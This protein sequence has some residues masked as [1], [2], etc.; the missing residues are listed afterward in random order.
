MSCSI[1]QSILEE[2]SKSYNVLYAKVPQKWSIST[3][4]YQEIIK[5]QNLQALHEWIQNNNWIPIPPPVLTNRSVLDVLVDSDMSNLSILRKMFACSILVPEQGQ[6][7]GVFLKCIQIALDEIL[8]NQKTVVYWIL[9]ACMST[10][11]RSAYFNMF[12]PF[13]VKNVWK[14]KINNSSSKDVESEH[15]KKLKKYKEAIAQADKI[16]EQIKKARPPSQKKA[17]DVH[18]PPKKAP[19]PACVGKVKFDRL[20]GSDF[21]IEQRAGTCWTNTSFHLLLLN[22][23]VRRRMW[24]YYTGLPTSEQQLFCT[25]PD[26]VCFPAN[27]NLASDT[28]RQDHVFKILMSTLVNQAIRSSTGRVMSVRNKN[29]GKRDFM[30]NAAALVLV[31]QQTYQKRRTEHQKANDAYKNWEA[32]KQEMSYRG[33][34]PNS[35]H[36]I[37]YLAFNRCNIHDVTIQLNVDDS[38]RGDT[39]LH[40]GVIRAQRAPPH[41]EV[42]SAAFAFDTGNS[43]NTSGGHVVTLYVDEDGQEYLWDSNG[44]Q[45][46]FNWRTAEAA[47]FHALLVRHLNPEY[48]FGLPHQTSYLTMLL[49]TPKRK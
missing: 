21:F 20:K 27:V 23:Y 9:I 2:F 49:W 46:K 3:R 44:I 41:L 47:D 34:L 38:Y 15:E 29:Y 14:L 10:H 18:E 8:P 16:I 36:Y 5:S 33:A 22:R 45:L 42:T 37:V 40:R 1:L 13:F 28:N 31:G 12:P 32:F 25:P 30:A 11:S 24:D 26:A 6:D 19:E 39:Y 43:V 48:K 4:K 17:P 35:I 7:L